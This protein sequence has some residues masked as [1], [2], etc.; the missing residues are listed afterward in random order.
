MRIVN[1]FCLGGYQVFFPPSWRQVIPCVTKVSACHHTLHANHWH[2]LWKIPPIIAVKSKVTTF[3]QVLRFIVNMFYCGRAAFTVF[4]HIDIKGVRP[5]LTRTAS[6]DDGYCEVTIPI[7]KGHH[8][9]CDVTMG[10]ARETALA[11]NTNIHGVKLKM[12]RYN[13]D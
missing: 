10:G 12:S 3:I 2:C 5:C 1:H 9:N 4:K 8:V 13:R 7:V 6:H 11:S